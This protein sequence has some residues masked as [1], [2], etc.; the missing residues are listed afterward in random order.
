MTFTRA[1]VPTAARP[2]P[3]KALV[4]IDFQNDF[5]DQTNGKLPV[6]NVDSFIDRLPAL[7]SSFR[8]KGLVVFAQTQFQEPRSN[9]APELGTFNV[10]LQEYLP[11]DPSPPT[12]PR[13]HR[14]GKSSVTLKSIDPEAFLQASIDDDHRAC[15]CDTHGGMLHDALASARDSRRDLSITK[16][17]Y[18]AFKDTSLLT[19]L[20]IRMI[21]H[22]Y[23]MGSLSNVSVYATVTDAVRHGLEVTLIEDCLG[24]RN[25]ECHNEA[26]QQMVDM[27]GASGTDYDEL[28]DDC[29]GLLGDVIREEDLGSKFQ[30]ALGPSTSNV[31]RSRSPLSI[32]H[33]Q[34]QV[35]SWLIEHTSRTA[36]RS[37]ETAIEADRLSDTAEVDTTHNYDSPST[38][39]SAFTI[40]RENTSDTTPPPTGSTPDLL[41]KDGEMI[42]TFSQRSSARRASDSTKYKVSRPRIRGSRPGSSRPMSAAIA[43][44]SQAALNERIVAAASTSP[45]AETLSPG[46]PE[47]PAADLPNSTEIP[48][49]Q[50]KS[51]GTPTHNTTEPLNSSDATTHPKPRG[52]RAKPNTAFLNPTSPIGQG[53]STITPN[54]LPI[55][56]ADDA[57]YSLKRDVKWQKMLHRTGE[58]PRLVAVQGD[59]DP[60]T[61][62][63]PIYRHPADE[64]PEMR[65]FDETVDMLRVAVEQY[66]G[67]SLNHVL[68]QYYRSGEDNISEHSD[69][70]LD[71]VRNSTIV[72]LSLGAQRI[73]TLRTKR[74]MAPPSSATTAPA[75][76]ST[77]QQHQ[78]GTTSPPEPPHPPKEHTEG[79]PRQTQRIPL[80]HNSLFTLGPQTNQYWLHSVRADKRPIL[81]KSPGELAFDGE[82]ISLT[83]RHIGTWVDFRTGEIW[84]GG[85]RCKARSTIEQA[86]EY[87]EGQEEKVE[88]E[89]KQKQKGRIL[90]GEEAEREGEAMIRAFGQENHLSSEWNWEEWYGRGFDVVNFETR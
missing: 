62:A 72:N 28:M 7:I 71:I 77:S 36:E 38:A 27:M 30:I 46:T 90:K 78:H 56:T 50:D 47:A 23:V 19:Q 83:F 6:P 55:N 14:R 42:R 87:Q 85:A 9:V 88:G 26:V 40:S 82:R 51:L 58:V 31:S 13:K 32:E 57:F 75:P 61:G 12:Q 60:V 24:Y 33:R 16:S 39:Q 67:H 2:E 29:M 18:S 76:A 4:L 86:G 11:R 25:L 49:C 37:S 65:P 69:K 45:E 89:E 81:E 22:V 43:E 44:A 80:P 68:I 54:I 79:P 74:A 20:R 84:G 5:I 17:H 15:L 73:M 8:S 53:D 63:Q 3:R 35:Q 70:T 59:I 1:S 34:Q 52:K 66:F 21:Q 48:Q 41:S 64:S 10:M